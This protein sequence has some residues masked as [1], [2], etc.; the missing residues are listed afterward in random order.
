MDAIPNY[1]ARRLRMPAP[2]HCAMVPG[3]TPVIAFGDP[4]TARVATLGLNPSRREILDRHGR[5][6]DGPQRRLETLRSLGG[7]DL[8]TAPDSVL[9][10]AFSACCRYFQGNPVNRLPVLTPIGVQA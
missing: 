5:E 9:E 10:H 4:R 8:A 1:I 3:S 7:D 2:A 6:L